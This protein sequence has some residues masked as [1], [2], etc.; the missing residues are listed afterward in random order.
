MPIRVRNLVL[1]G[2]KNIRSFQR[3]TS[4]SCKKPCNLSQICN[5]QSGRCV[6]KSGK[7]GQLLNLKKSRSRDKSSSK[8]SAKP[9]VKRTKR[10]EKESRK[11]PKVDE[12][13]EARKKSSPERKSMPVTITGQK[14]EI[15]I[16]RLID[17]VNPLLPFPGKK[18]VISFKV[19][20]DFLS[21]Y[22]TS[23]LTEFL[24]NNRRYLEGCSMRQKLILSGYTQGGDELVNMYLLKDF[25]N[26]R[27]YIFNSWRSGGN[28]VNYMFNPM[29]YQL[30][31]LGGPENVHSMQSWLQGLED[32]VLVKMIMSSIEKY[33]GELTRIFDKSP[34]LTKPIVVY[35]GTKSE[36][37]KDKSDIFHNTTFMSTSLSPKVALVFI[38]TL[39]RCCFKEI[40]LVP[41][42][43]AIFL[44]SLTQQ[45]KEVEVLLPPGTKFRIKEIIKDITQIPQNL[46]ELQLFQSFE[47][48]N[49]KVAVLRQIV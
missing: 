47:G 40:H 41:G 25:Q 37:Y 2:S 9:Q 31:E 46:E 45:P 3:M 48:E 16:I 44:E 18:Q 23:N 32:E 15:P 28:L 13:M 42:A 22:N 43:K 6:L 33:I 38:N 39:Y 49:A 27:Q 8:L 19:S 10:P 12:P 30:R 1:Q 7:I 35:R 26:L 24:D 5:P 14:I 11:I 17:P 29:Y 20:K 21:D 4:K 36:Y 34:K